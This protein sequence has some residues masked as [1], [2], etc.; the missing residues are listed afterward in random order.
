VFPG[1]TPKDGVYRD[2]RRCQPS[3]AQSCFQPGRALCSATACS[4][5]ETEG[6][7]DPGAKK[8]ALGIREPNSGRRT[9]QKRGVG[10]WNQTGRDSSAFPQGKNGLGWQNRHHGGIVFALW[11]VLYGGTRQQPAQPTVPRSGGCKPSS[12]RALDQIT[13]NAIG[14]KSARKWYRRVAIGLHSSDRITRP[15]R[16]SIGAKRAEG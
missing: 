10:E 3:C 15:G 14:R 6:I 16:S 2:T 13:G 1:K 8:E 5:A 9:S 7:H 12:Q 4:H 11:T